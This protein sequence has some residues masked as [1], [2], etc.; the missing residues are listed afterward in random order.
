MEVKDRTP[1]QLAALAKRMLERVRRQNPRERFDAMV[2]SGLIDEE[3]HL[4]SDLS[5]SGETQTDS[6]AH[7]AE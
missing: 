4:R 1:E 6:T 3:G 5:D 2:R 7:P